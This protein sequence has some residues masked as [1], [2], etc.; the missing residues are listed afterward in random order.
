MAINR[1]RVAL[2]IA[3]LGTVAASPLTT[4]IG[5]VAKTFS[6]LDALTAAERSDLLAGANRRDITDSVAGLLAWVHTNEP[7]GVVDARAVRGR[8]RWSSN[9]FS[10]LPVCRARLLTGSVEI[11]KDFNQGPVTIPSEFAWQMDDTRFAPSQEISALRT[12]ASPAA[13]LVQT[14]VQSVWCNGEVGQRWLQLRYP[15]DAGRLSIGAPIALM[16]LQPFPA[17]THRLASNLDISSTQIAIAEPAEAARTIGDSSVYLRIGSEI[18]QGTVSANGSTVAVESRGALGTTPSTHNRGST[19]QLMVSRVFLVQ[20]IANGRVRLDQPL[21]FSFQSGIG[22]VGAYRSRLEG[23]FTIDGA[24]NRRRSD[25]VTY[26]GLATTLSRGFFASG[27][28]LITNCPHGGF[29][30]MGAMEAVVRGSAIRGCGRPDLDLGAAVWGF[31]GGR[32]NEIDFSELADG[33]LALAIDNKSFGVPFYGLVDGERG[34]TYRFGRVSNFEYSVEVSGA[35][36]NSVTIN[37]LGRGIASPAYDD[38]AASGQTRTPVRSRRNRV[39]IANGAAG[40]R[41]RGADAALNQ[42]TSGSPT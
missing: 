35:S 16:G 23:R 11:T 6:L 21:P 19:I 5:P 20:E 18:L 41:S 34:S 42:T 2:G 1:R 37:D 32:D 40:V 8:W 29:I 27:D 22:R 33:H 39:H 4:Q 30:Q 31:G 24:F 38:G 10:E 3:G 26:H 7:G 25:V 14:H 12:D 17:I 15:S 9:P 28:F 36:D 13:A